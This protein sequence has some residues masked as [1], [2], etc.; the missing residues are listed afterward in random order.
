MIG[1]K[2]AGGWLE[3]AAG[4]ISL[5]IS[6]P[7]FQ[8][9]SV[10]GTLSYPF[11]VPLS[12]LNQLRLNFPHVRADQ[13]EHIA[14]EPCEFY[15]D[16]VLRWVG[17]LAYLSVDEEKQLYEYHFLA[18]AAD[19]QS[20]IDGVKL[21]GLDLGTAPLSL[22][23]NAPLYALPCVRNVAFYDADKVAYCQVLNYY[24]G[25]AYQAL[26]GG[27]RS[28]LVPFLR[29]VP[30]LQRVLAAVG[31]GVSGP[32]LARPEVQQLVVYS[33]R[34]A[35][36][37]QGNVLV[38]FALNRYVPNL[39]VADFLLALQKLFALGYDFHPVRRQVRLR[40]LG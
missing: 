23:P 33:D 21:P 2:V 1:L 5:D 38:S 40:A 36:D 19:L 30:L 4:T 9:D 24:Q 37:A 13:G 26:P 20:R 18:D 31:Y 22:A 6:N 11:G 27:K 35:E 15:I 17:S 25:G 34:A 8:A 3:L 12:P 32:W 28:P 39:P 29:L 16:G 10:P 14:P 7:F